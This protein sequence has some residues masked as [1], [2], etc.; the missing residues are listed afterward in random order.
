MEKMIRQIVDMDIKARE[1]T[2]AAQKEKLE[3]EKSINEKTSQLREE[4]LSRA[5]RRIQINKELENVILDQEWAKV[6]AHYD[7]Q[8]HRINL[9]YARC[10]DEWVEAIVN[11][12]LSE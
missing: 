9:L 11:R 2:E 1:I 7:E 6:N 8:L 3:S 5:R 12:V 4:V 10:G